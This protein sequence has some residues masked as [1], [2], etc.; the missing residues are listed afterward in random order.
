[1]RKTLGVL[2]ALAMVL[3]I[4]GT[5]TGTID[6]LIRGSDVKNGS[7]TWRDIAHGSIGPGRIANRSLTWRELAPRSI[8][9]GRLAEGSIRFLVADR[10]TDTNPSFGGI[11]V[12]D[13]PGVAA[14]SGEPQDLSDGESLYPAVNLAA[15]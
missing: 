9:P 12:V 11:R 13:V 14:G 4:T 5:A 7:L 10:L 1:M 3:A 6:R 8:G 15:G 2:G